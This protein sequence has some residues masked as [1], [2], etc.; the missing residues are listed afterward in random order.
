VIWCPSGCLAVIQIDA[1]QGKP[2]ARKLVAPL[3]HGQFGK[4]VREWAQ[5][6]CHSFMR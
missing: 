5:I 4:Y 3:Y 2:I 1:W 6:G